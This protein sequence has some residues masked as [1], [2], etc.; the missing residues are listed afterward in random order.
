MGVSKI[1]YYGE[2]LLDLTAD[3]VTAD[4]LAQ[5]VTAHNAAGEQ[6]TGTAATQDPYEAINR[7]NAVNI[8]NTGYTTLMARGEK[9]LDATTFDA[10]TDWGAE[11]VN[12]AIAWRYE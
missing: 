10:V 4:T 9:L 5:G 3:T 11:L 6:I 2:T 8:A 1:D 12:G 7:T